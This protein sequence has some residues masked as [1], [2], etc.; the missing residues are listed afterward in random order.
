[1][2]LIDTDLIQIGVRIPTQLNRD[3]NIEAAVTDG[4]SKQ[5]VINDCLRRGYAARK[6]EVSH[7]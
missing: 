4:A 7:V 6:A 2:A 1:M 5:D 3:L